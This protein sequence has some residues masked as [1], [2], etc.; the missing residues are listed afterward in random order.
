METCTFILFLISY[1]MTVLINPGIPSRN[2]YNGYYK[3]KNNSE[4]NRCNKCNIIVPKTFKITHCDICNVC[5]M[6]YDHHCPWTGKCIGRYN[7]IFFFCFLTF[8]ISYLMMSLIS[9]I[10]FIIVLEENE[11]LKKRKIRKI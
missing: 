4:L 1:L 6:N 9:F 7:I 10:T 5:V 8:L 2:Y 11:L 3:S